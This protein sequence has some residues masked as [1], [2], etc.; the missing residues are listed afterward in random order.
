[1]RSSR[2][3][4]PIIVVFVSLFFI[5][6]LHAN[7]LSISGSNTLG[8]KLIPSCAKAFLAANGGENPLIR[9]NAVNEFNV[10]AQNSDEIF[11]IQAHGSSTGFKALLSGEASIAM[12]SRAIKDKEVKQLASYGDMLSADAEHAVALDGLAILVNKNN[13]VTQLSTQQ[14][15]DIFSGRITN[16]AEVGGEDRAITLYARDENSGTWDTFKNLV[17]GKIYQL[18]SS[19]QR[20]ESN[21]DLSDHVSIDIEGIGFSGLASVRAA[22]LIA[23]SD[24]ETEAVLPTRLSVATED[25]PL[26][27]RLF[28]YT[29]LSLKDERVEQFVEFC[30]SVEGQKI[31]ADVGFV[32]QNVI[33]VKQQFAPNAPVR[34]QQLAVNSK[35]LSVNFRF[36]PG[37]SQLDNKAVRDVKRLAEFLRAPENKGRP[38]YLVG[39]SDKGKTDH[40]AELLSRF[41]ALSVWA[42]L[43]KQGLLV[44]ESMGFG[45]FMPVAS[46][47]NDVSKWKNSRVE[48]WMADDASTYIG[49][50]ESLSLR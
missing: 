35:R 6:H 13:P 37:S 43:Y 11:N 12:S 10:S 33:A 5:S 21:D 31:V 9:M 40:S 25:Y 45:A 27:R 4:N 30:Q 49:G 20:F 44:H 41:R 36:K 42:E 38:L 34:Y 2:V 16:W 8:A 47:A 50:V 29:P 1:M 39:F 14:I 28:L 23:V 15:A 18:H 19:A 26:T 46:N 24:D 48:V 17:L 3:F 22:K 7:S 32:S